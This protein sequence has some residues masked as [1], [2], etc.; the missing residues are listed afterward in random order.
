M[1]A[2]KRWKDTTPGQKRYLQAVTDAYFMS[3]EHSAEEVA[4]Q[5]VLTAACKRIGV[6]ESEVTFDCRLCSDDGM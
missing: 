6:D 4:L 5:I 3:P 2:M 1:L